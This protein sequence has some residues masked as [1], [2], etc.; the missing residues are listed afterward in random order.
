[1]L[2]LPTVAQKDPDKQRVR[3]VSIPISIYTKTELEQGQTEEMLSVDRL[4]VRENNV[5]Q[6]I[7]SIRSRTDVPLSLA[8]LIQDDLS[9]DFNLHLRDISKFV[10]A[11]PRGSRVMV[12]YIGGGALNIRQRFT[13]DLN[14]AANSFRI[15]FSSPSS[16]P[17]SPYDGLSEALDKF[18]AL[19]AGRRAILLVSN[20]LDLSNGIASSSPGQS[21]AL[22]Q[23]I[24]KA[25]RKNV[26]VYSIYA[27]TSET[28]NASFGVMNGQ[29]SLTALADET[30][31]RAFIYGTIT[32]IN[33]QPILKQLDLL[34]GRQF[35]LSYLSENMKK[36]YYKVSVTS[37]NPE[38]KIEHPKG[39][40]YR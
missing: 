33:F 12:A 16:A 30:G 26:A 13:E 11:L 8:I 28:V 21:L 19:P 14:K 2:A 3:T 1:M 10:Q 32:P 5:E 23:T 15:V 7:L 35:L 25:Q 18:E 39:Y 24:L 37:T 31:G 36:G 27:T 38:V 40:Y 4:I 20:G 9:S 34:V 17:R 22:Q 29:A 6:T